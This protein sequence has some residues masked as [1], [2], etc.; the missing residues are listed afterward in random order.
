M[1]SAGESWSLPPLV[2]HP[3]RPERREDWIDNLE[4]AVTAWPV[5]V[6]ARLGDPRVTRL[7]AGI[8]ALEDQYRNLDE[9]AMSAHTEALRVRLRRDASCL[10]G[11]AEAFALVREVSHRT[12]GLRHYDVQLAGGYAMLNGTVAEMDTGEGKT[13]TATL[14]AATAALAGTPVHIVT[15]NDYLAQ[16]DAENMGPLYEALGLTVGTIVHGLQPPQR[17]AAYACDITYA[18][19]KEIAFDYLRDRI[20]LGNRPNSLAIKLKRV[21]GTRQGEGTVMRGLHFAIVDEADSVLVDEAR[22]PLI[23]SRETPPDQEQQWAETSLDLVKQLEI[24]QDYKILRTERRV[25]LTAAGRERL[26]GLGNELGG[27]WRSSVRREESARQALTALHLFQRGDHY[28]VQ[29]DKV[30]IVDE[31]SGRIMADRSWSEGLH[32]LVEA[33][34]EC[35]VTGRKVPMARITYQRFFRRYQRL[36][37]MTGTA[38]EVSREFWAVYR[39]AVTRIP[40]NLPMHRHRLPTRVLTSAERKWQAIA[41]RAGELREAG[42]AVLIGTRSVVAS[43]TLSEL[44]TDA[45]LEHEV[46]SAAQD[47]H[48]AEIIAR[49]G[50]SGRITVA[51]NMAGRGVDIPVDEEVLEKGG[52]HVI[53]SERHDASRIDRQ[54]AGRCGR[55]GEPGAVQAILSLEDPLLELIYPALVRWTGALPRSFRNPAALFVFRKAQRRA[56]RAHSAAR[57]ALLKQDQKLG[58]LLAFS[59]G[60]E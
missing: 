21:Q 30:Q 52:L 28:L 27:I 26:A 58:V 1:S 40:T 36:A 42:H 55:H 43:E 5:V 7:V 31:Y 17:K 47:K 41:E 11:V 54:L 16:R 60:L 13:L 10:E 49:A 19:N 53:L 48:E 2:Y 14:A 35:A 59:G 39:L 4:M 3:E 32:Q 20:A 15:V 24:D 6:R 56:E 34:E 18:S 12:L 37:G 33:K 29:D 22:T 25:E 51:T 8:N 44:L 50:E 45:G 9:I 57:R 23:I 46:L 38:R